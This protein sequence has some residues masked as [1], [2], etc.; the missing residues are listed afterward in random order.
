[1]KPYLLFR[2][3]NDNPS[4]GWDDFLD[5]FDTYEEA[6]SITKYIPDGDWQIV[7]NGE[8]FDRKGRS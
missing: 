4:G 1:M 7:Y 8:I 6:L 2:W 5:G 3:Y